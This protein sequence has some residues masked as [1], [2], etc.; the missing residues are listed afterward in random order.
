[1]AGYGFAR[2]RRA[3]SPLTLG[4]GS[5]SHLVD[6]GD[7]DEVMGS[8]EAMTPERGRSVESTRRERTNS[9]VQLSQ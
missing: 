4:G 8:P 5:P 2:L 6:L 3:A 7:L 1:M 9:S